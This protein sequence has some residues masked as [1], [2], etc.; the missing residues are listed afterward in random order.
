MKFSTKGRYALRFMVELAE[1]PGEEPVSLSVI[2][3]R[4]GIS[5]K[6]LE[7]IVSSLSHAGLVS[8]SRG[9]Q[10][11]YR[12]SRSASQITAGDIL[13]ATE[14]SLAPVPCLRNQVEPCNLCFGC[15]TRSFWNGLNDAIGAYV[16]SVSLES[17]A[18]QYRLNAFSV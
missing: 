17:L 7:Q 5:V 16:D 13:R 1:W 11:G 12:L 4:Q 10:G 18:E 9:S 2:A 8:A 14:G 15:N 6:Y 3:E